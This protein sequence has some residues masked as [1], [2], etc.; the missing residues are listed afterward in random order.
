MPCNRWA[1]AAAAR[2]PPGSR[3]AR[4]RRSRL[5]AAAGL[6]LLDDTDLRAALPSLDLPVRLLHGAEDALIP[7]GAA[8]AM[9]DAL[10]QCRLTLLDDCGHAPLLSRPD[11]C[12]ALMEGF[13]AEPD[14]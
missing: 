2:S 7:A 1:T 4:R 11:D 14:R 10:P 13:L 5:L 3:N 9:N 6:Q 8:I 12:A